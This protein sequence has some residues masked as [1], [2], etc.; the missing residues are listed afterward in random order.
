MSE[1]KKFIMKKIFIHCYLTTIISLIFFGFQTQLACGQTDN[2]F[3][4]TGAGASLTTGDYNAFY[5]D[6]AGASVTSGSFNI[7]MGSAAGRDH[8][9]TEKNVYIGYQSGMEKY[10]NNL[11]YS[12]STFDNT[13]VGYRTGSRNSGG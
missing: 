7:F 6:S 3:Q 8:T 5:G 13:F 11:P 9:N 4:G 10:R 2:E 1:Y 12:S